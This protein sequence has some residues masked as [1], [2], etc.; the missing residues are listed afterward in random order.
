MLI[1]DYSN[2]RFGI[3]INSFDNF[4]E[5]LN[6]LRSLYLSYDPNTR[7]WTFGVNRI[8]EILLWLEKNNIDGY[9]L[10]PAAQEMFES[11]K[12]YNNK[13]EL[14]YFR[15]AT[16]D[17]SILTPGTTLYKFQ[18]EGIN[19]LL[20][21]NKSYVADDAGL[22]KSI[23]SICTFSQWYKEGKIDAIFIVVRTG[24]SYHWKREILQFSNQFIEDDIQIINNDNKSL[25]FKDLKKKII[26]VPNHLL[27]N[28]FAQY[29]DNKKTK[30]SK[31][32]WNSGTLYDIKMNWNKNSICLV[33]DESHEM[34][35]SK[36]V[37][38]RVIMAYAYQFD[39]KLLLS[40]TPAINKFED[41]WAGIFLIDNSILGMS[42]NAFKIQ[43]SKKIGD[44]WGIYNIQE[45]DED[46]ILKVKNKISSHILKRL[47]KDIPEMKTKQLIKSVFLEMN[48]LQKDLYKAF[49]Q[50]EV[51]RIEQEYDK[52]TVRFIFQKFPYLLQIV[53]N[54]DLLKGKIQSDEVLKYLNKWNFNDDPRVVFLTGAL[55]EYIENQKEKIVVF[56]NHPLTLSSLSERFKKYKP[57][58]LHGNTGDDE[59]SRQNKIDKFND[60]N[61]ENKIFFLSTLLGG[62]GINLNYACHH[63]IFF[64]LPHSTTL[65][66]Q[67]ID[68]IYRITNTFDAIIEI[69]LLDATIDLIRYQTNINRTLLNDSFLN[70]ELSKE[71]LKNL[72]NGI[73]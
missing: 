32:R 48:P 44:K 63:V 19:W 60:V 41:W 1:V 73:I 45:Y 52:V 42:E 31:I 29:R 68:R 62:A 3:T 46:A 55:E 26:I 64:S 13:S 57:L 5:N 14:K 58:I 50:N 38:T 21:R 28:I 23:E 22:G 35:N 20:K 69:P 49:M 61:S 24:L 40:A 2:N 15:S 72:L 43:I 34:K 33:I 10:T 18:E 6:F 8:D 16:L 70:Q 65:Y 37:R 36:A 71:T 47:K 59:K 11:F 7:E 25:I 56:D 51:N 27:G 53:D 12:E 67:A 54:P 9:R 39:Y 30:L 17:K 4:D 66:R